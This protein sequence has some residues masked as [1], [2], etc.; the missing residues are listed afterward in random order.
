MKRPLAFLLTLGMLALGA[1]GCK[2][3]ADDETSG[4]VS[5][6]GQVLNEESNAPVASAFVTVMPYNILLETDAQGRYSRDVEIDSTMELTLRA[7]KDG[8]T[9]SSVNVLALAGRKIEAPTMRIKQTVGDKPVSGRATNIMLLKQSAQAIG[10]KESGSEEVARL[11]FQVADSAGRPVILDKS[12]QVRFSLGERPGGGEFIFPA[13]GQTDAN[14]QIDVNLSAGTRAGVVQVVAEA[15]VDG[16]T[17]RSLPVSVAVH[18]GLP[19]QAHFSLG[20]ARYNFQGLRLFGA[21]NAVSVVVGD[22]YGNPVKPNTAVYFTTTHGVIEGSAL[23]SEQGRGTVQLISANPLPPNGIGIV[24]AT[25]ADD[26]QRQVVQK[27]PVVF[28]GAPI[29][30]LQPGAAQLG[31][32]YVL[33]VSDENGNPLVEGSSITVSVEGTK[34]KATGHTS[35]RLDDTVFLGGMGYEHVRR[36][37]GITQFYFRT[38]VDGASKEDGEA[39]I[40]TITISVDGPNGKLT[41][42]VGPDGIPAGKRAGANYRLLPD[43]SLEARIAD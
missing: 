1:A 29:L 2:S 7:A 11:T 16:R 38:T 15:T 18:G 31:Q 27:I 13:Q 9:Y 39:K 14:G 5:L 36:G 22:K 35:V 34:V 20:P 23:T 19:D 25:T 32:G 10:V 8:F 30:R 33:T 21:E 37:N 4:T 26:Q 28:S 17:L 6:S 43:G 41:M 3:T 42:V 40:E 12:A 24:T